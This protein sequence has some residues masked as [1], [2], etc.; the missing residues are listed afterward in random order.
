MSAFLD[1][2]TELWDD[3]LRQVNSREDVLTLSLCSH[4]LRD[5]AEREL[6]R[7]PDL[8]EHQPDT[9]YSREETRIRLR[10][11]ART[12]VARPDIGLLVNELRVSVFKQPIY[13]DPPSYIDMEE[14]VGSFSGR[15]AN[16]MR[17]LLLVAEKVGF[18]LILL[19]HGGVQGQL[20]LLLHFLPRLHHILLRLWGDIPLLAYACEHHL[21][22]DDML[23]GLR[24][25]RRLD[26]QTMREFP[27]SFG[28]ILPFLTLPRL[29][30]LRATGFYSTSGVN[31]EEKS[32]HIG[33]RYDQLLLLAIGDWARGS[34]A[35]MEEDVIPHPT[36]P[37]D[38][39]NV[40]QL[41]LEDVSLHGSYLEGRF[42]GDI[43][44]S[45][46]KLERVCVDLGSEAKDPKL[47]V[48]LAMPD[49]HMH[50]ASLTKLTII[51]PYN[52]ACSPIG[53]LAEFTSLQHLELPFSALFGSPTD[54]LST[55]YHS[56]NPLDHLLPASVRMVELNLGIWNLV[57]ACG[58]MR[59]PASW[60]TTQ[61]RLR[62]L[63]A[64]RMKWLNFGTSDNV[65]SILNSLGVLENVPI[66]FDPP[67]P[68]PPRVNSV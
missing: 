52:D 57:R 64:F 65:D 16:D 50:A 58:A 28:N 13:D 31:K 46:Q 25:V 8:F 4:R 14:A 26:V 42:F 6:Y 11:L 48:R 55:S 41:L 2:P 49:L 21:T 63:A 56:H 22:G 19:T 59:L 36:R 39:S 34:T 33:N 35:R 67:L 44:K 61:T 10:Q 68:L 51:Y 12:I 30:T 9:S 45:C 60:P 3:I 7:S 66:E 40:G 37:V 47:A 1:F 53:S 29:R 20:L 15:E 38:D 18:P 17:E 32:L 24:S 5:V 27:I 54:T 62:S 23:P 43:I